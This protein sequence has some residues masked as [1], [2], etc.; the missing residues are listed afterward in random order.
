MALQRLEG[1]PAALAARA[2]SLSASA[3]AIQ[4][5]AEALFALSFAGSGDA[6]E[7]VTGRADDA[8]GKVKDAHRR[9][10]GTASALVTYAVELGDAHRK[11]DAIINE[12]HAD[13]NMA[14]GLD[15]RMLDLR[16][17]REQ[18][19]ATSP[20]DPR[21]D[22]IDDTMR[23]LAY[24]RDNYE[25]QVHEA[26]S[27]L[28]QLRDDVDAAAARAISR[29]DD[30]LGSTNDGLW[31]KVGDVLDKIGDFLAVVA[32]WVADVL[33]T[34]I[35][36]IL[37]VI[38]ALVALVLLVVAIALIL[39]WL[40]LV[41]PLLLTLGR[42][43]LLSFLI[44]GMDQ[45]RTQLLAIM[46][47]IALPLVGALLLWRVL[48]DVLA[49]DPKVTPLDS[50]DIDAREQQKAQA[51]AE[52]VSAL[53]SLKDFVDA[54]GYT[55]GMGG[56]DRS[57]VDIRKV[58]GPD[59]VERWVVTLPSTQDWVVQNGDTPATND[60]DS[61]LALMLTPEMKTQY[62]RA[63]LDAMAQAGIGRD[64]PVMLVGFS[65]G[66]IMAG[67]LAANRS[68]AYNFEAVFVYGAPI[69]A[70]DIPERTKVLSIQHTGDVVPG[71]D[72]TH[73][74]P[75][76]PNHVT[77]A[78]DAHDGTIGVTSHNNAKYG[79]TAAY[80]PEL[81]PYQHFFDTFSGAVTEQRQYTWQE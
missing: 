59:G 48:S 55:D 77:V 33:A 32:K 10:D 29:I 16:H 75:N 54:E 11:A 38:L 58:A 4:N 49:P 8:A 57:V 60:L 45:W 14:A 78:L 31:D 56:E 25:S 22:D 18:L 40:A 12:S 81:A 53:Y 62:E 7:V 72:L 9:Y 69:D 2:D 5:A 21:L 35:T 41:A 73:P 28:A 3:R 23:Q 79:E 68:N 24:R 51:A 30:A 64:D 19:D 36:A 67:H 74:K 37:V 15:A 71:L 65:Q 27:Q 1:N 46:V 66:G 20:G 34:I 47:S 50:D 43:L 17:T 76:T 70:M 26:L 52:D 39:A 13:Q 6:L 42:L 63:V 61:N 80:S 44:P